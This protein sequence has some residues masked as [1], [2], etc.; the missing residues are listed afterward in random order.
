M[1]WKRVVFLFCLAATSFD[2]FAAESQ[3]IDCEY[4]SLGCR[5]MFYFSPILGEGELWQNGRRV[6][7]ASVTWKQIFSGVLGY[8]LFASLPWKQHIARPNSKKSFPAKGWDLL[9]TN[10]QGFLCIK[11]KRHSLRERESKDKS[12]YYGQARASSIRNCQWED[13]DGALVLQL[14]YVGKAR[15]GC[16]I[17]NLSYSSCLSSEEALGLAM[18]NSP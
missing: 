15:C 11:N 7:R 16:R 2:S 5:G 12:C 18:S 8:E 9:R 17:Y 10:S 6:L 4:C 3:R 1:T 13:E 14:A